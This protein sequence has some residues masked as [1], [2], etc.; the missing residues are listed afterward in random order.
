M[1][2]GSA[3]SL[4]GKSRPASSRPA[5][6]RRPRPKRVV[7]ARALGSRV[8]GRI[9]RGGPLEPRCAS[10]CISRRLRAVPPRR[11]RRDHLAPAALDHW[12]RWRRL[13]APHRPPLLHHQLTHRALPRRHRRQRPHRRARREQRERTRLRTIRPLLTLARSRIRRLHRTHLLPLEERR[14]GD[15]CAR[16]C[17]NRIRPLLACT[18]LEWRL[19]RLRPA[20]LRL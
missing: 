19:R 14:C 20:T 5:S 2:L 1:S 16:R 10:Q 17:R 15:A 6:T 9:L 4:D 7:V 12:P 11:A 8:L 18:R 13:L 3:V